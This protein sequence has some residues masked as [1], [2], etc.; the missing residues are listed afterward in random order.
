MMGKA[1]S[2][3]GK[4]AHVQLRGMSSIAGVGKISS[5]YT[6]GKEDPTNAEEARALIVRSALLKESGVLQTDMARTLWF[7]S[8]KPLPLPGS[9]SGT[10]STTAVIS[11]DK[12]RLNASQLKA[13]RAIMDNQRVSVI[14]GGPG[15]GKTVSS[16]FLQ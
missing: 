10:S 15:T 6:I 3:E 2:V 16:L 4:A 11:W 12:R 5:V 8:K 13:V 9:G 7:P 14:H 1:T